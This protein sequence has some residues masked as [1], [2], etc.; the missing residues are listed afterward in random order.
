MGMNARDLI[1][2]DNATSGKSE[3]GFYAMKVTDAKE[4]QSESKAFVE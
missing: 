2:R 1:G 4:N 3:G